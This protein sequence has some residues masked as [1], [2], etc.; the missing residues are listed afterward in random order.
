M[1]P[2]LLAEL[3]EGDENEFTK[4]DGWMGGWMG[5]GITERDLYSPCVANKNDTS[6]HTTVQESFSSSQI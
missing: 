2:P 1:I 3:E 6:Q 4:W 5:R